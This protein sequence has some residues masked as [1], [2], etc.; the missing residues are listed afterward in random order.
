MKKL[1]EKD[2]FGITFALFDYRSGT[3]R[4]KMLNHFESNGRKRWLGIEVIRERKYSPVISFKGNIWHSDICDDQSSA[5]SPS[6][7]YRVEIIYNYTAKSLRNRAS[8]WRSASIFDACITYVAWQFHR[9]TAQEFLYCS[10]NQY[11]ITFPATQD[12]L[13]SR[14]TIS[15]SS[16]FLCCSVPTQPLRASEQACS[17]GCPP[18]TATSIR[19]IVSIGT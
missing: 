1:N 9:H 5:A 15:D 3:F 14:I 7:S 11:C 12:P 18:T 4:Q 17:A 10:V 8:K 6:L 2:L 19:S 13:R 16:P